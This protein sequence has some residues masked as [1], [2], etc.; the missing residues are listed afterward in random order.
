MQLETKQ[1]VGAQGYRKRKKNPKTEQCKREALFSPV[2]EFMCL[3]VCCSASQKNK[4]LPNQSRAFGG[5][6]SDKGLNHSCKDRGGKKPLKAHSGARQHQENAV[7]SA[8]FPFSP[9]AAFPF[10]LAKSLSRS[11]GKI[12]ERGVKLFCEIPP[13]YAASVWG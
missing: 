3:F 11:T 4:E 12:F 10:S 6:P 7:A 8:A 13:G 9:D 2:E 1:R 5:I